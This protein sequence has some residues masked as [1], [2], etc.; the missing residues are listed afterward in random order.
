MKYYIGIDIGLQGGIVILDKDG[1]IKEF[2][3]MPKDKSGIDI[4]ELDKI[5]WEYEGSPCMVIFEKLGPIFGSSKKTAWSM[6]VQ[7]GLMKTICSIRSLP[8]TEVQAKVWQKEMFQGIPAITKAGKSS[9]DTK[10]MAL[11][12]FKRLYPKVDF[13]RP[14]ADKQYDGLI[15]A[16]LMADY[17]KRKNL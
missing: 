6:G 2:H 15:D 7:V 8:Y 3:N 5:F 13:K 10:A 14:K 11:E 1:T 9:L 4:I 12:A 16:L 17:G